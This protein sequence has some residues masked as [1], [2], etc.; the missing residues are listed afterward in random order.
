MKVLA[1]TFLNI[2]FAAQNWCFEKL[3]CFFYI[4]CLSAWMQSFRTHTVF[5]TSYMTSQLP[6]FKRGLPLNL[7]VTFLLNIS[8]GILENLLNKLPS[9]LL[10]RVFPLF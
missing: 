3:T 9:N 5:V 6:D 7:D 1:C 4:R 10:S 2:E 8:Y